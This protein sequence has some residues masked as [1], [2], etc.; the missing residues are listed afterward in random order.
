[1]NW[2]AII[3]LCA[4]QVNFFLWIYVFALFKNNRP[5]NAYLYF[6]TACMGWTL[7][8][9]FAWSIHSVTVATV[10][11][12]LQMPCW[13]GA[14]FLFC[15]FVYELV[16]RRR[17]AMYWFFA[18]GAAVFSAIGML[19]PLIHKSVALVSWG[20]LPT[21]G[22][23]FNP[24]IAWCVVGVTVYG[25]A[26][27]F[28]HLRR[29]PGVLRMQLT[30]ILAGIIIFFVAA[31]FVNVV[32][33]IY[34]GLITIPSLGSSLTCIQSIFVFAAIVRY[35]FLAISIPQ[36]ASDLFAKSR[37]GI[38]LFD[39]EG[40]VVEINGIAQSFF[41]IDPA[42]A[43]GLRGVDFIPSPY[44]PAVDCSD[45]KIVLTGARSKRVARLSQHPV[46]QGDE[47][48][49]RLLIVRDITQEMRSDEEKALLEEEVRRSQEQKMIAIGQLAGGLAHDFNNCLTGIMG[50]AQLLAVEPLSSKKKESYI[51][52]IMT[53]SSQAGVL[54]RNLLTFSRKG[55]QT[56]TLI[57]VARIVGDS[58]SI[59]QRTIDKNIT[60]LY[61]NSAADTVI[62][63]DDA[64]LQNVF[65]NMGI[66][67]SHA[68]PEGGKLTFH[69]RNTV[70]DKDF[71]DASS[72]EI[73]PGSFVEIEIRDT[74]CGMTPE[75]QGRIF[76]PF[77][78]TKE[79]GKGT[80]LGLAAAY[81]T[82]QHHHGTITVYSEVG[83]GT[84]FH[85]YLPLSENQAT[86]SISEEE[87]VPGSGT[88]LLIDDEEIIRL[89]AKRL[90]E[91]LG[92]TVLVAAEGSVG[93]E[94][95]RERHEMID[96]VILDMIMPGMGG[97][98]AYTRIR[99]IDGTAK[100]IVSSGFSRESDIIEM[101][102][103]GLRGFIGKPFRLAELSQLIAGVISKK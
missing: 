81:G 77:Y 46:N 79:R 56:S 102:K 85:L 34:G 41:G 84:V 11:L 80:G 7:I 45:L 52:M 53:A 43:R 27:S 75:V 31:V 60:I 66:N 87:V 70:L 89:T 82:I 8:D 76:E 78:T 17:D 26:L 29:A 2:Y 18:L 63:G 72:F 74:G 49:G 3:P 40:T 14:G 38:I 101:K 51:A 88:I 92:Y 32:M 58:I 20:T 13:L 98:E 23:L 16:G 57:D 97:R 62:I 33:V 47:F 22:P 99:E 94:M 100:V 48:I 55:N 73:E 42:Q 61:E 6:V 12:R 93:V 37:D 25:I 69:L 68:M 96:L 44:D 83:K 9:F 64:M 103:I 39:R 65:L 91:S 35:Q 67:A 24:A 15:N 5:G 30:L 90:L 1:M 71:C 86:A 10:L 36:A 54:I 59:L 28:I 4:F 21:V 50:A 95:Y 19:T